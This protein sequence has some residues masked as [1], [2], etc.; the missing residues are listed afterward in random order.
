MQERENTFPKR[1]TGNLCFAQR[2]V[3]TGGF[4]KLG[5]GSIAAAPSGDR[6]VAGGAC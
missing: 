6:A 1:G 5:A 2:V 3:G 4:D